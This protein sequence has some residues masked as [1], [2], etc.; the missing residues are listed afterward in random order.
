MPATPHGLPTGVEGTFAHL[1]GLSNADGASFSD[2]ALTDLAKK[3]M[4]QPDDPKDGADDEENPYVP[5]GYTY[6]GQF[7]DH[8][9]TFDT[10]SNF[11]DPSSAARASDERT[12]RFDLDNVYGR[13]P[14]DQPYLYSDDFKLL[15]GDDLDIGRPDVMRN[16]YGRAII[17]DPRNDENS[18]VVQIQAAMILFH[19]RMVNR[20]L[21]G[22]G[23][24]ALSGRAAFDWARSRVIHHYQ[25]ILLDDFL[26]RIVDP[27]SPAVKPIFEALRAGEM[28]RLRL[29]ELAKGSYMPLEFAVAAYRFGHSMIRPGYRLATEPGDGTTKLFPIF[30]GDAGGLRGFQRLDKARGIEWRLFFHP[31]LEAGTP[32]AG[33][34]VA[35][36]NDDAN[37][38]HRTQ[39]AYKIDTMLVAPVG[40]LPP[41]VAADPANLAARNLRRGKL[42]HLASGQKMASRLGI[43]VLP[44]DRLS[45]RNKDQFNDRIALHKI[46]SEFTNNAPLWF[47][48]L[49]EAEQGVID[50]FGKNPNVDPKTI[51]TRLT[52]VGAAIVVETFVGLMLSD[53]DSV[54]GP[55]G[56]NFVSINGNP[57]FSMRELLTD[58]GGLP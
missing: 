47:Y 54:L 12:P 34:A 50:A 9:L 45:V 15:M 43:P 13:G 41:A 56:R 49:A 29:Y 33:A 8:D 36:S 44:E 23:T 22:Q 42:F 55:A 21:E 7:V 2:A 17:G 1:R 11:N 46:N 35:A 20:A 37:K 57:V 3:M 6:F 51:G 53:P 39:F 24:P 31:E 16:K 32:L 30:R 58:I 52:G 26:P 25:R 27:D 18:I 4:L 38:R 5:A 28:P 10:T 40:T 19:N 48:I 14:D